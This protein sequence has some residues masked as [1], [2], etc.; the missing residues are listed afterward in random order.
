MHADGIT[1]RAELVAAIAKVD[2]ERL[3]LDAKEGAAKAPSL[4][5]DAGIR[6]AT[7]ASVALLAKVWKVASGA[8]RREVVNILAAAV[9]LEAGK[10]PMPTWVAKEALARTHS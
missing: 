6:R 7:L 1:S 4:L 10:D 3:K 8:E 2:A 9:G 5:S